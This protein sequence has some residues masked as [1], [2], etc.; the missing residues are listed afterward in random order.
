ML[1]KT[2]SKSDTLILINQRTC[3]MFAWLICVLT[4]NKSLHLLR[5]INHYKVTVLQETAFTME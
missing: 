5:L 3:H 1:L 4:I 2:N